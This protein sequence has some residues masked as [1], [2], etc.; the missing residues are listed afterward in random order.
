MPS[1]KDTQDK[2]KYTDPPIRSFRENQIAR[3]AE[4]RQSAEAAREAA[5]EKEDFAN[6]RKASTKVQELLSSSIGYNPAVTNY[7]AIIGR[8]GGYRDDAMMGSMT[9]LPNT[10]YIEG[11][12]VENST[13]RSRAN[14]SGTYGIHPDDRDTNELANAIRHRE[15]ITYT[16]R[17]HRIAPT[18]GGVTMGEIAQSLK[19]ATNDIKRIVLMS[20]YRAGYS[21]DEI[22]SYFPNVEQIITAKEG[23]AT[24]ATQSSTLF[25]GKENPRRQEVDDILAKMG[26]HYTLQNYAGGQTNPIYK[27]SDWL[28]NPPPDFRYLP[29]PGETEPS[30]P[31]PEPPPIR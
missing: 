24:S 21:P 27:T 28:T 9:N 1:P 14:P 5:L 17:A 22:K 15:D 18:R 2:P 29:H 12:G 31:D 10:L 16:T 23:E 19:G 13:L 7:A 20:C 11:H 30:L 6:Y 26:K 3:E 4:A 8:P 25:Y